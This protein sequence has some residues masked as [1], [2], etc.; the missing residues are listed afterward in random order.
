M[1]RTTMKRLLAGSVSQQYNSSHYY[2]FETYVHSDV[3]QDIDFILGGNDG[4]SLFV[5][6]AFQAGWWVWQ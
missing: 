5:D 2:V 1:R 4:H 3:T 6:G